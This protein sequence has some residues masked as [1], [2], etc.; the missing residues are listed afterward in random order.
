MFQHF[1]CRW[2]EWQKLFAAKNHFVRASVAHEF[3]I[4]WSDTVLLWANTSICVKGD[5]Q[6]RHHSMRRP[7]ITSFSCSNLKKLINSKMGNC[8]IATLVIYNTL[9]LFSGIKI[10]TNLKHTQSIDHR[11]TNCQLGGEHYQLSYEVDVNN[12]VLVL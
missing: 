11:W 6:S 4:L 7:P 2:L 1:E 3:I 8:Y 9:Y 12:I 10:K 5:G